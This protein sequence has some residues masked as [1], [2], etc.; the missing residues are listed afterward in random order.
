M[1]N[2]RRCLSPLRGARAH[3]P[4]SRFSELAQSAARLTM[5]RSRSLRLP[6][7]V[8]PGTIRILRFLAPRV[9]DLAGGEK[10]HRTEDRRLDLLARIGFRNDRVAYAL[11]H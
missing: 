9:G 11:A 1:L 7:P 4:T 8:P 5:R 3:R 6:L 2:R 10:A